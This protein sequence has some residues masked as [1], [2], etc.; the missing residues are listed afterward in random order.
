MYV[1]ARSRRLGRLVG[2]S[3][4]AAVA[5]AFLILL[6]LVSNEATPAASFGPTAG[7]VWR[8]HVASLQGSWTVPRILNNSR[9]SASTW[10]GVQ[11]PGTPKPFIQIGSN[12]AEG[13][14]PGDAP[15][16]HYDTFWSDVR[17]GSH[18]HA[19]FRVNPGDDLSA[20]LT[21]AHDKWTLAIL[22]KSSGAGARFSTSAETGAPFEE[23][24]WMQEDVANGAA[25][26]L[27]YPQLSAVGFHR[28]AV[29]SA[30]PSTARLAAEWMSADGKSVAP[31]PLHDGSFTLEPA[32]AL[33]GAGKQYLRI[34][35]PEN[36]AA[37]AFY[38]QLV[39][40]TATTPYSQIASASSKFAAALQ[41][42]IQA[43]AHARWPA[44][45]QGP[46][47]TL[48]GDMGVLLDRLRS[49]PS[50]SAAGLAAWRAAL[51]RETEADAVGGAEDA[52]RSELNVP[53]VAAR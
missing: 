27:P 48:I 32:P 49:A 20:S 50:R 12:E 43:A 15:E 53:L 8:G 38:A 9:G 18:R 36:A 22:D 29:N 26:P 34:S 33:S 4:L 11:A 3:A 51:T 21:L 25:K 45:A 47:Q 31:S 2:L 14:R 17:Q 1:N 7:Y 46:A 10:I 28:L 39:R 42:S 37:Y 24:E 30:T 41:A 6:A 16:A 19:L 23:A 52:L 35:G 40:W 44:S 13:Y 5:I